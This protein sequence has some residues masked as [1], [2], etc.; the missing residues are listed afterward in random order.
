MSLSFLA[1][2]LEKSSTEVA[3][4][5]GGRQ[6]TRQKKDSSLVTDTDLA[7]EKIIIAAIKQYYPEDAIFAEE[8]GRSTTERKPGQ[9]V[10]IID[11]LDGTT[12]FAN[13]YPYFCVS[14]GRGFF[15]EKGLISMTL[16]GI[17]DP[18]SKKIYTA[19]LGK[20]AFVDGKK[21]FVATTTELKNSFLVTGLYYS[22][23]QDL[24]DE[25]GR[26][27]RVAGF[28]SAIRR[29]GAAALDMALVA[30]GIFDAF[31]ERGL[32]PWDVAA[33]S[34]LIKEAGGDV[35]PYGGNPDYDSYSIESDSIICGNP[36]VVSLLRELM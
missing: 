3:K 7:S 18:I 32:Q 28:C 12:N 2:I 23:G 22:K 34:V 29:D 20:G 10:W 13:G 15:N 31:W 16:G 26:F 4:R 27:Q 21:M 30:E 6:I 1:E 33:G 17:A 14:I 19:E 9:H 11:P 5:F 25:V 36:K 35:L 8:S 24:E